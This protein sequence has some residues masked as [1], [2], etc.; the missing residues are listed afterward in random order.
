M[1][2]QELERVMQRALRE[3]AFRDLLR[4]NPGAALASYELTADE[5]AMIMGAQSPA[6]QAS[7]PA[8]DQESANPG[9]FRV[10]PPA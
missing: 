8:P 9:V 5:R 4:D 7:A 2:I 10:E 3:E 6:P 1:S